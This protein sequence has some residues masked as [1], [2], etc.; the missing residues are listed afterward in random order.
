MSCG[1]CFITSAARV[2]R[3]RQPS[4]ARRLRRTEGERRLR[5]DR[6]AAVGRDQVRALLAQARGC[7]QLAEHPELCGR[8]VT[9]VA[10]PGEQRRFI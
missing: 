10:G 3:G 1:S 2:H 9:N 5:L 6:C 7:G 8:C 4:A